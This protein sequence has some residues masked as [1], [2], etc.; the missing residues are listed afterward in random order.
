MEIP[1]IYITQEREWLC[2]WGNSRNQKTSKEGSFTETASD[3]EVTETWDMRLGACSAH[4]VNKHRDVTGET[5]VQE[6]DRMP[7]KTDTNNW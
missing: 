6:Y 2:K 3:P 7:D 5:Q 1:T 4:E